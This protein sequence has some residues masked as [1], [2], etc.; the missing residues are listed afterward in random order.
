MAVGFAIVG[1]Y[2]KRYG[3][4]WRAVG[5]RR[6]SVLRTLKYLGGLLL[7]FILLANL[8]FVIVKYFVPGFNADQ[9][10]TNDF[11]AAKDAHRG[12]AFLALVVL[13]PIFEE[14]MFRGFMFPALSK[15]FGLV[16]GA[17]VS[18]VVFGLAHGQ[19]NLFVYTF[20]L[21]LFLS[22]M[23]TRLGS[24]VPGIL[25]HMLNNYLAFLH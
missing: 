19:P 21:G 16:W 10:Q 15:R 4:T 5:W 11:I 7:A 8:A 9:P 1:G 24:I 18:S 20:L 12:L 23:Y 2:L 25:L 14:T 17:V 3:A 6:A 13:P 22:F